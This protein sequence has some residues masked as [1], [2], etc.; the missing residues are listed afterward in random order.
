MQLK[1]R[2]NPESM[3]LLHGNKGYR[4]TGFRKLESFLL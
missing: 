3:V 2:G 4:N 1:S